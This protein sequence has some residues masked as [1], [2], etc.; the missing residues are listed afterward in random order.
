[1]SGSLKKIGFD[2]NDKS[3]VKLVRPS[4]I[5]TVDPIIQECFNRDRFVWGDNP[6]LRWAVDNTQRVRSGVKNKTG[7]D[8]GNY[9]YSKIRAKE[10]KKRYVYGAGGRYVR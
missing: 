3:R 10:P 4:D 9:V 6:P 1:M 2:A 8:T 7:V 5:M